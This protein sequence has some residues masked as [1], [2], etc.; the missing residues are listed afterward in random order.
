MKICGSVY[1][2]FLITVL[3]VT[4]FFVYKKRFMDAGESGEK[5]FKA[6]EIPL[7][8]AFIVVPIVVFIIVVIMCRYGYQN[9]AYIPAIFVN[10][11]SWNYIT[12]LADL[13]KNG[14]L[15]PIPGTDEPR[16]TTPIPNN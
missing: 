3:N 7:I 2:A 15:E 10:G 4:M 12:D 11:L 9:I 14:F 8:M 1:I 6:A 13:Y 16:N 5:L